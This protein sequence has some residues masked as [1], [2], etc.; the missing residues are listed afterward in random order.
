[1]QSF[2]SVELAAQSI[3]EQMSGKICLGIPLGLGKPN[4]LVNALYQ[5][6]VKDSSIKL[7][8]Y[9][10]LSLE[11]PKGSSGLEERFL[12][13]FAD[14]VFGDYQ[15]LDYIKA[16]KSKTLPKNISVQEFF[17]R[18]GAELN[19]HYAQQHYL[20]TNYTHAARDLNNRGVN[21]VAQGF[22]VEG[23]GN[24]KRYSMSCNPEV[25][26]DLLPLIEK[27]KAAGETI[28]VVGQVNTHL[29]FI[30]NH[31]QVDENNVDILIEDPTCNTTLYSMPNMP[32]NMAEHF[33]GLNASA[34]VKDNGTIQIGIGALG[35]ALTYSLLLREK[36][37]KVY[38]EALMNIGSSHLFA[39]EIN[40]MG[41]ISSFNKGLYACSEM[42]TYGILRL[43]E[44]GVIRKTVKD[45]DGKDILLHG[46]F[47]L[48]PKDMYKRL[49]E[50]PKSLRSKIDLLN[51]SYVNHLYGDEEIKRRQRAHGRFI[52]SAFTV[53]LM[54][55]GVADQLE[56]G[57]VLSGVGGQYNF[58]AQAHELEDARSI[59]L[60]RATRNSGGEVSSNI[61]WSY[62]HTTI[63]RHLRDVVVTEY[64]IADLRS[65][66][67]AECIKAMLNIADSQFQESLLEQAKAQ[68][69]VENDYQI[70][71]AFSNNTPEHLKTTFDKYYK[72]GIFPD[73]PLGSDFDDVEKKLIKAL[74]WLK[75]HVKPAKFFDLVKN[76]AVSE[77]EEKE[78]YDPLRRMSLENPSNLKERVHKQLLMAALSATKS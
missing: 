70:P 40:E 27:R 5:K 71:K 43:I 17:V 31:A 74:A 77:K 8:I 51:I 59:L 29:P 58:V 55:A 20:S 32:V 65:K 16:I 22:A 23:E 78:F 39:R 26:L 41:G 37:N 68:G 4:Q 21:V 75:S 1:M 46:G 67:D 11:K 35:D 30:E 19:S 7:D 34:L 64:G 44:E 76:L 24:N 15:D 2:E 50:M 28:L 69:K 9:T 54:G 73:F 33:I 52:N 49:R 42:F 72:E 3:I 18:P 57:R 25:S 62:G 36:N 63:P 60:V 14:R 48:G 13:P 45:K 47:F 53:T 6:A 56:D 10:A 12:K 66:T 61:V 38:Q